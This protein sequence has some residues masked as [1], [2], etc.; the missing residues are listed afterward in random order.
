MQTEDRDYAQLLIDRAVSAAKDAMRGEIKEMLI[1]AERRIGQG[2]NALLIPQGDK[3]TEIKIE[4]NRQN[5]RIERLEKRV[6]VVENNQ[7]GQRQF[8]A[9]V[10]AA[11]SVVTGIVM[12]TVQIA[13]SVFVK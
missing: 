1:D 10:V 2:M 3:L 11:A 13:I 6:G 12:F 8:V 4:L 9:G 7:K 5:N